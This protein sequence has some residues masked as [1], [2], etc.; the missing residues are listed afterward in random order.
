MEEL[1]KL[2]AEKTGLSEEVSRQAVEVVLG[3]LKQRLPDPIAGRLDD[4]L[5]SAD[6]GLDLGDLAAGLGSLLGNK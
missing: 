5:A 1:V 2:V 4:L 6:S 3:F